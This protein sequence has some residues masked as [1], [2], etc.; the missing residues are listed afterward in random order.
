ILPA[1]ARFC[2][3]CGTALPPLVAP[4]AQRNQAGGMVFMPPPGPLS[5]PVNPSGVVS[6]PGGPQVGAPG[7]PSVPG[8][9]Q[10]GGFTVPSAPG[11]VQT[12]QP[13]GGPPWH[14]APG[15]GVPVQAVPQ[16]VGQATAGTA[17]KVGLGLTAKII[18]VVGALTVVAASAVT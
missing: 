13:W 18:A 5:G 10:G 8:G 7:V 17:G 16:G 3:R 15:Q 2:G 9:P 14:V 1:Q 12:G 4:E 6:A 11:G